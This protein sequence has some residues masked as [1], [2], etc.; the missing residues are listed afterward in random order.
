[1][2]PDAAKKG[3]ALVESG[4]T[5]LDELARKAASRGGL[6][7][8]LAGELADDAS[9]LRSPHY[10][11][12]ERV[13]EIT[14]GSVALDLDKKTFR[15]LDKHGDIPPSAEIRADTTDLPS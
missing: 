8:K 1:M 10:V 2:S 11:P 15:R 4:A 6:A 14:D 12:A 7:G 5:K 3:D 9:F 13:A